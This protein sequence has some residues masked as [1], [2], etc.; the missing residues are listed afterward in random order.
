VAA[1]AV[2]FVGWGDVRFEVKV[3]IMVVVSVAMVVVLA[4]A[5]IMQVPVAMTEVTYYRGKY[6]AM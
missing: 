4:V 2:A 1:V 6:D 5:I 3:M